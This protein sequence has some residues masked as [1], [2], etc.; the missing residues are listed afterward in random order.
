MQNVLKKPIKVPQIMIGEEPILDYFLENESKFSDL[1]YLITYKNYLRKEKSDYSNESEFLVYEGSKAIIPHL[2]R[3]KRYFGNSKMIKCDESE[4]S[5]R[6]A[7]KRFIRI[8]ENFLFF[9]AMLFVIHQGNTYRLKET[10]GFLQ[11]YFWN[12]QTVKII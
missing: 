2:S 5:N 6:R 1:N 9:D 4:I 7:Y 10:K 3:G 11:L 12:R 8:N